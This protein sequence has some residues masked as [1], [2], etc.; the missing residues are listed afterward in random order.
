MKIGDKI[1]IEKIRQDEKQKRRN[2]E[3]EKK[4]KAKRR[5]DKEGV[6][7]STSGEGAVKFDMSDS[8]KEHVS[9]L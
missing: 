8:E 1:E 9:R 5:R 3:K 6:Y 7:Y 2:G 4:R